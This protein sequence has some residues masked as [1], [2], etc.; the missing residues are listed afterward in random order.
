MFNILNKKKIIIGLL[1]ISIFLIINPSFDIKAEFDPPTA[2]IELVNG[3][4]ILTDSIKDP[5]YFW[6][7]SDYGI[8]YAEYLGPNETIWQPYVLG[9]I[10]EKNS[11]NGKYTFRVFDELG[12]SNQCHIYFDIVAPIGRIYTD[13]EEFENN[14]E[15]NNEYFYF[16]A[17]DEMC[18]L[19]LI[20]AKIPNTKKYV[21]YKNNTKLTESGTYYFYA[22]DNAGN[23][24]ITYSVT[25]NKNPMV[26]I[27][28][29]EENNSIYLTWEEE[30]YLVFVNDLPYAKGEVF[31]EEAS[32]ELLVID[33]NGRRGYEMFIIDHSYKYIETVRP[34]CK[35]DGYVLYRCITCNIEKEE[36]DRDKLP[37]NLYEEEFSA[38]CTD[39]G[40]IL[41]K[42]LN[43]D[44]EEKEL[45]SNP[46]GHSYIEE[47]LEVSCTVDGGRIIR[48]ERCNYIKYLDPIKANGHNYDTKIIEN[49]NCE[50]EGLKR[51]I[52]LN[53]G[54]AYEQKIPK[55]NH[56]YILIDEIINYDN[57][58]KIKEKVLKCHNCGEII[59]NKELLDFANEDIN[60]IV[61][62][63]SQ[64]LVIILVSL[65]GVW[66]VYMGIKY[67]T[68]KNKKEVVEAKKYIINYIIGLVVIFGIIMLTPLLISGIKS[69]L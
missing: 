39:N 3:G 12:N 37:H 69:I 67:F 22:K 14:S 6:A 52:C 16:E 64:Y 58:Q 51:F 21:E 41:K 20:Y 11:E 30:D 44:Y 29:I 57:N 7:T 42:C 50:K 34:T 40:Y 13:N 53:C 66:S 24:S 68:A 63:N 4:D 54:E 32:Y 35:K 25:L 49:A 65:S 60:N 23:I 36:K 10:F 47:Y 61:K 45:I 38:T 56:N 9:T 19:D 48:C 43:C 8:A 5:F 46:I 31:Y 15:I 26:D 2:T 33:G 62:D 17:T 18:G 27:V 55:L 59:K 1:L 28:Y